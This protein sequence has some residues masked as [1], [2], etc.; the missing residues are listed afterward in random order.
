[1]L[2]MP[3]R[4]LPNYQL[5]SVRRTRMETA[6]HPPYS[7]DLPPFDFLL[8]GSALESLARLSFEG[9]DEFLEAVQGALEGIE[10]GTLEAVFIELMDPL[11]KCIP[12]NWEYTDSTKGKTV[13]ESSLICTVLRC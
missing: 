10:K 11:R 12:T 6:P 7:P 9:R 8:F 1:M 4:T 2:T 3:A 13:E 5:N